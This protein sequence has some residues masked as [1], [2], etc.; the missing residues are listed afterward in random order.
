[1]GLLSNYSVFCVANNNARIEH[2]I[3]VG[4][5]IQLSLLFTTVKRLT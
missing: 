2:P 5:Y 3:Y 1:M 4:Y